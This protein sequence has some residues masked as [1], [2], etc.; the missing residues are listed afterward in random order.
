[1]VRAAN[2]LGKGDVTDIYGSGSK[3][4]KADATG[5]EIS[6][7]PFSCRKVA[8]FVEDIL[9]VVAAVDDVVNQAVVDGSQGAGHGG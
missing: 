4:G 6:D 5:Q 8:A 9:A 2:G 3:C 1:M 7:V